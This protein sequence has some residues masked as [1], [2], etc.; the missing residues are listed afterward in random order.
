[1]NMSNKEVFIKTK[2]YLETYG[3]IKGSSGIRKIGDVESLCLM[4]AVAWVKIRE[5]TNESFNQYMN[6]WNSLRECLTDILKTEFKYEGQI[7]WWN[8]KFETTE[9]DVMNLLDIA[10]A[11]SN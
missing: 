4:D 3:W 1:M 9:K 2:E 5:G 6:S 7:T 10:I 8:D 11:R